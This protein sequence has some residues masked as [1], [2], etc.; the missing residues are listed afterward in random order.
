MIS[1]MKSKKLDADEEAETVYGRWWNMLQEELLSRS[2]ALVGAGE[3]SKC[4]G[5]PLVLTVN[6]GCGASH[7]VCG[8]G[9]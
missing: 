5:T 8:S 6:R 4:Q 2:L 3:V 7:G 9:S 1:L